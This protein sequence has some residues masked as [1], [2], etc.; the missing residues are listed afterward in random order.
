MGLAESLRSRR[1]A[2]SGPTAVLDAKPQ[3]ASS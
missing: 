1:T 3:E 2:S